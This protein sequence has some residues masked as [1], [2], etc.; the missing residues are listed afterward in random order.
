MKLVSVNVGLPRDVEWR[1]EKVRTSIFKAPVTGRVRVGA[2]NL[3]GD[4]QSDLSVHG[5]VEKA[6][7][8]Y[9]SEHYAFWRSELGLAE[10]ASGAF[11]ENLT[12]EGLTEEVLCI[13][14][15]VRCGSAEL[16]VTQ[17]RQPCFKLG[18]RFA[19]PDVVKR[20]QKSGRSG[21]YFAV[22]R[23]GELAAGDSLELVATDG[24]RVSIA[25]AT[26]AFYDR[27]ADPALVR[28]LAQLKPLSASWRGHFRKVLEHRV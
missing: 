5:G 17:P 9:P 20:F 19:R 1:G 27:H 11:G 8:G 28:R 21:F 18:L 15:R 4:R 14:D 23:E 22:T 10:L 25:D 12:T 13:G 24:D 16:S 6:L 26:R 2:E 7:Y 3:D